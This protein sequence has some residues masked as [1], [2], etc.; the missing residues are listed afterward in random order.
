MIG[1]TLKILTLGVPNFLTFGDL[2]AITPAS[3]GHADAA[4]EPFDK[5]RLTA[6]SLDSPR[7]EE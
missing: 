5:N 3:N 2:S 6:C 7:P 4:I 1:R